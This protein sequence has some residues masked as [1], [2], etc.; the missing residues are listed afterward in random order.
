MKNG[1]YFHI[2]NVMIWFSKLVHKELKLPKES[3]PN[4]AKRFWQTFT[5]TAKFQELI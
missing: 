2:E 4:F 3:F 1:I 5:E